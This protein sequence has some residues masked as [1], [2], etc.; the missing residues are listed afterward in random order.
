MVTFLE[1]EDMVP[2]SCLW[3]QFV[4][5]GTHPPPLCTKENRCRVPTSWQDNSETWL[6]V[7][8]LLEI[9]S[10][11]LQTALSNS[12][13]LCA[14]I[15]N[16]ALSIALRLL[17]CGISSTDGL[18]FALPP[19]AIISTASVGVCVPRVYMLVGVLVLVICGA[20]LCSDM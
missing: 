3:S 17:V 5:F 8:R 18:S 4:V 7:Q 1:C 11:Y 20:S 15:V 12:R 9:L 2:H 6:E 14:Q 19:H 16:Q 10:G 13:S